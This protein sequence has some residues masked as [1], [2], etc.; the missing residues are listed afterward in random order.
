[1]MFDE[2][3]ETWFEEHLYKWVCIYI[4]I[5][6]GDA[7]K[8]AYDNYDTSIVFEVPMGSRF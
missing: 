8:M 5:K 3:R 4:Y 7:L 1:M 6:L 2:D